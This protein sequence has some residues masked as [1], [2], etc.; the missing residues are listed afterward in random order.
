[1]PHSAGTI[2]GS[3]ICTEQN[4]SEMAAAVWQWYLPVPSLPQSGDL[5]VGQRSEIAVPVH[6]KK[7][8]F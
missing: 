3:C 7:T 5:W 6:L 1:M 4:D 8:V 2:N